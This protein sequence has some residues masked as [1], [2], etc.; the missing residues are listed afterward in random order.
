MMKLAFL[1]AAGV[2]AEVPVCQTHWQQTFMVEDDAGGSKP[3][4]SLAT[5][6]IPAGTVSETGLKE[7]E[8]VY[9]S[10]VYACVACFNELA[11]TKSCDAI[12]GSACHAYDVMTGFGTHEVEQVEAGADKKSMKTIKDSEME[13]WT[14]A[15]DSNG[16][17][18]PEGASHCG[19]IVY[20]AMNPKATQQVVDAAC[21]RGDAFCDDKKNK[22]EDCCTGLVPEDNLCSD[23]KLCCGEENTVTIGKTVAEAQA[24][25]E[26][27]Q[28]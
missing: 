15:V 10:A 23:G 6:G 14:Y 1:G 24:L 18:V 17:G 25:C 7:G 12:M 2:L 8:G 19:P 22:F 26:Q 11:S 5:M 4:F 9:E 16:S 20:K 3:K 13:Q 27:K 28:T 21:S